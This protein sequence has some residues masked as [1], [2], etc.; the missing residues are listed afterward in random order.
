LI[1]CDCTGY[2]F[3]NFHVPLFICT[4]LIIDCHEIIPFY[5]ES[6]EAAPEGLLKEFGYPCSIIA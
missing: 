5:L 4:V 3:C 1:R 6:A 2:S